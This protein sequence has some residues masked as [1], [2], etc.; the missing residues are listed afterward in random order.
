MGAFVS[1]ANYKSRYPPQFHTAFIPSLAF[2]AGPITLGFFI[3]VAVIAVGD[4]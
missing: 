4:F 1:R 3:P 2:S